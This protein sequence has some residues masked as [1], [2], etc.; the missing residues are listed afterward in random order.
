MKICPKCEAINSDAA[1]FC[2]KCGAPLGASLH[3]GGGVGTTSNGSQ[4]GGYN[5]PTPPTP[6][7]PRPPKPDSKMLW[8]ILD[9]LF[10]C[11][12]LG[13]VAIIKASKVD[14]LYASGNYDAALA[15]ANE[16]SKYIKYSIIGFV[17]FVVLYVAAIL[18][19]AMNL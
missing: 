7:P 8:A 4:T 5:P 17:I 14:D 11:L 15:A 9:T 3:G 18:I 12:P 19:T 2:S 16:A 1:Q 13:I 10:C 6:P